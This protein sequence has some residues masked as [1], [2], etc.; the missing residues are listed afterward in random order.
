M[1]P[2]RRAH[3]GYA[4]GRRAKAVQFLHV[5]DEI[6]DLAHDA[7]DIGDAYVTLCV[8]AG[9]AAADAITAHRLEL[10]HSGDNHHEATT[11]LRQIRPD[12]GELA[13]HLAALLGLKTKA[14]Y[15]HRSVSGQ[16]RV[17]AG[18]RAHALVDA[19]RSL[20]LA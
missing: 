12:G 5:A 10:Y 1:S 13:G 8:H 14:G 2:N 4:A 11:L 17:Q 19:A 9:I 18:R 20:P 3:A 6:M 15:T 7:A 16:E